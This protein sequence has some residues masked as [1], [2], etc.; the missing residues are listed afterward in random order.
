MTNLGSLMKQAREAQARM[1]EADRALADVRVEGESGGGAVRATVDGKG[2]VKAVR[3]APE[4]LVP[5]DAAMLEDLIVAA[6]ASARD[7]ADARAAEEMK[8][9]TGALPLPPGFKPF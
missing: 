1:A 2:A 7:K 9:I 8:R 4:L 3:I 5:D 6:C